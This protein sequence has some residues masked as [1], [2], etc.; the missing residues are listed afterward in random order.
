MRSLLF[1]G[2]ATNPGPCYVLRFPVLVS[3]R[4][5]YDDKPPTTQTIEFDRR[6]PLRLIAAVGAGTADTCGLLPDGN[7]ARMRS[8]PGQPIVLFNAF[9]PECNA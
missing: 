5:G 7:A 6:R 3:F 1:T 2:T 4:S 9:L 8:E